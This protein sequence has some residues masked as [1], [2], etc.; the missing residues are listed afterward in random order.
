MRPVPERHDV[1]PNAV[2]ELT[3][4]THFVLIRRRNQ[5]TH[6]YRVIDWGL[7]TGDYRRLA[8]GGDPKVG[9]PGDVGGESAGWLTA[10]GENYGPA[11]G[12]AFPQRGKE[13]RVKLRR[14]PCATAAPI[15]QALRIQHA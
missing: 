9:R 2:E 7:G 11:G 14:C 6:G 4:L 3:D 8:A 5:Q 10:Q 1:E 13:L 12:R 15:W